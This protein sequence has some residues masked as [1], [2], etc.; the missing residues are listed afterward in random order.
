M[1]KLREYASHL[2]SMSVVVGFG[3]AYT[4]YYLF[5]VAKK[6]MLVGKDRRLMQFLL[7][8]CPTLSEK[9]FP[10]FWCI[11]ARA[12]TIM[13]SVLMEKPA[14]EPYRCERLELPDGG[15]VFL[16]WLD[17]HK[18]P[19]SPDTDIRPTVIILPG[20]TGSAD[21]N[22]VL[23]FVDD[24]TKLGYR[25]VV[26]NN[27]GNGGATLRTPRTYCAAN[28]EDMHCVVNH[29]KQNYPKAPLIGVGVSLGG[30]ILVNY[31]AK[32][33]R[34][35]GLQ[36]AMV[37]STAWNIFKSTDSL[38]TPLNYF[39]FNHFLTRLL[40][41]AVLRNIHMYENHV[42][43]DVNHVLQSRTIRDFD[44]RFTS[45]MFGYQSV[46]HYYQDASTFNKLHAVKIPVLVLTSADD[47]FSP[48]SSLPL[49]EVKQHPNMVFAVTSHGGH[50]GF[51][52]GWLPR[53]KNYMDRVLSQYIDAIFKHADKELI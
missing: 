46:S 35:C 21:A 22:Y 24:I 38:E 5:C 53:G 7:N 2:Q 19:S 40:R 25:T 8:H 4:A 13:R 32:T 15:E 31:L 37:I 20:L 39:L 50:I 28:T 44:E 42:E 52:E 29:I 48:K 33:G 47:P 6:P 41:D 26:F 16:H 1:E 3:V 27:R 12:N 14:M 45:K 9:Y 23:S 30:M 18:S 11:E 51:C 43:L 36:A 34:D 10:T 49:E 17:N